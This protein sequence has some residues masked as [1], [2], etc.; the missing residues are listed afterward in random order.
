MKNE[1]NKKRGFTLIELLVVIAIIG[2]LSSV[3][4]ASLNSARLKARDAQRLSEVR[5]LQTALELYYN[6]NGHYPISAGC[7]GSGTL[8]G[9]CNS[10]QTKVG[11]H[12]IEDNGT[13]N[14]LAPFIS[15]DPVDPKQGTVVTDLQTDGGSSISYFSAGYGGPGK[16]YMIVFGLENHSNKIQDQDGVTTCDVPGNSPPR[17]FHYGNLDGTDGIVTLGVSC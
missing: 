4:L 8:S 14:V 3:V 17:R 5:Q 15:K 6:E 11:D 16:W 9:W 12:W 2:I 7:G 1:Q 10:I 13:E